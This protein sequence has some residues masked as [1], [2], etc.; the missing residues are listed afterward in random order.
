MLPYFQRVLY[1]VAAVGWDETSILNQYQPHQSPY[2]EILGSG[3]PFK[4]FSY[5]V[6]TILTV[7]WVES[8]SPI[9][10]NSAIEFGKQF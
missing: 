2:L 1:S 3:D 4:D 8:S 6:N 9:P 10:S 7:R 5:L